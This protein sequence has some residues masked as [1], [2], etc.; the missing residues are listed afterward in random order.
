[1]ARRSKPA[2]SQFF[3]KLAGVLDSQLGYVTT[4]DVKRAGFTQALLNYYQKKGE[5]AQVAR[6]VYRWCSYPKSDAENVMVA[7][8]WAK[9][10]GIF[11]GWTALCLYG[12]KP[13]SSHANPLSE[14]VEL[15]LPPGHQPKSVPDWLH[16]TFD[17]I[18]EMDIGTRIPW[19]VVSA[20][21]AFVE[22]LR[23]APRDRSLEEAMRRGIA[24][25]LWSRA[26]LIAAGERLFDSESDSVISARLEAFASQ[27]T[28]HLQHQP[29][30]LTRTA[31]R[32]VGRRSEIEETKR[33][34]ETG[35]RVVTFA[36][37]PGI[38]KTRLA[39]RYLV[40]FGGAFQG[41]ALFCDLSAA[42]D[43]EDV[44]DAMANTLGLSLAEH[45]ELSSTA[46]SLGKGLAARGCT[47]VVL[48]NFEQLVETAHDTVDVWLRSA[49][50]VQFLVTSRE[51]LRLS[52]ESVLVVPPLI[53]EENSTSG[54]DPTNSAPVQL[55]VDRVKKVHPGY[56]V[57]EELDDVVKLLA[58]LDHIPLAIELAATRMTLLTAS[59]LTQR[60]QENMELLALRSGQSAL[61]HSTMTAAINWS[62]EL[63][64]PWEKQALVQCSV[65][66][67][68]F[69]PAAA[70]AIIDVSPF[71]QAPTVVVILEALCEQSLLRARPSERARGFRLQ[72][73]QCIQQ[74][75]DKKLADQP[76]LANAAAHNHAV[77]YTTNGADWAR[78]SPQSEADGTGLKRIWEE[79][80]NLMRVA[81]TP[82]K[83]ATEA[84][85]AVRAVLVLHTHFIMHGPWRVHEALLERSTQLCEEWALAAKLRI[86]VFLAQSD[87]KHGRV[88]YTARQALFE[89]A[90]QL[91]ETIGDNVLLASILAKKANLLCQ[92]GKHQ[93]AEGLADRAITLLAGNSDPSI[94]AV[95]ESV[96]GRISFHQGDLVG[97]SHRYQN[98]ARLYSQAG[99]PRFS[100]ANLANAGLA[101]KNLGRFQQAKKKLFASLK[102]FRELG[103][104][105]NEGIQLGNLGNMYAEVG[106]LDVA[107]RCFNAAL[108]IHQLTGNKYSEAHCVR[109]LGDIAL[110]RSHTSQAQEL[111][112][113]A[114]SQMAQFGWL[115]DEALIHGDLAVV[116]ALIGDLN[117]ARARIEQ[118]LTSPVFSD[119][120]RIHAIFLG[121]LAGIM[122]GQGEIELAQSTIAHAENLLDPER[123]PI[124]RQIVSVYRALI[125]RE[126]GVAKHLEADETQDTVAQNVEARLTDAWRYSPSNE[127]YPWGG[128]SWAQRSAELRLALLLV[129]RTM[130]ESEWHW[131]RA[132]ALDWESRALVITPDMA[133]I[134]CPSGQ[135]MA[136][137][138]RPSIGGVFQKLVEKRR[139][140]P[141]QSVTTE[142][143][144]DAGW[145]RERVLPEAGTSRVY[146][147]VSTLRRLGLGEC[148]TTTDSGYLLSPSAPLLLVTS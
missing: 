144:L 115:W 15:V 65:F 97:A 91:A 24:R 10:R 53:A 131:A 86:E 58:L 11:T 32:F 52:D 71:P 130:T 2:R 27:H 29:S 80:D 134:R 63:L 105:S 16:V 20:P 108:S 37:P 66:S 76:H 96:K 90:E 14:H 117:G 132:L 59:Q 23:R 22:C 38:G 82:V 33:L 123:H 118:A 51:P 100:A 62:W 103:F 28:D 148:L 110:Y 137:A 64:E 12:L 73:F 30:G 3:K 128:P 40:L 101:Q 34:L 9:W 77:Y 107:Q 122:A 87:A 126:L 114:L 145:P 69:T 47:L 136:V 106:Q 112:E 78:P 99:N 67:G 39:Q 60:L 70:E 143:L 113:R 104:R 79:R 57:E 45:D 54:S 5:L 17:V 7:W 146:S 19:R 138:E 141:G 42:R 61:R 31:G 125:E 111:Y 129:R 85:L 83:T 116:R 127:E 75:C 121:R 25:E 18:D 44:C 93:D 35:T 81:K 124:D 21:C 68:G 49:Q 89:Q 142:D 94:L 102:T 119:N 50:E 48:D 46:M 43:A 41:G 135:P 74:F 72:Q 98:A 140:A 4:A 95:I 26:D 13:P 56:R 147:A 120:P 84:K 139:R 133:W 88:S 36:G 55:F 92:H 1:M 6:G 8:L 109:Q